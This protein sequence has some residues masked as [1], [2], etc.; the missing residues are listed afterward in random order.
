M[1]LCRLAAQAGSGRIYD[2]FCGIGNVL[3]ATVRWIDQ[4]GQALSDFAYTGREHES[5][6]ACIA[7][8]NILAHRGDPHIYFPI[9]DRE[10][11][12]SKRSPKSLNSA[13]DTGPYHVIL[14]DLPFATEINHSS[15]YRSAPDPAFTH[16]ISAVARLDSDRDAVF[17]VPHVSL[18]VTDGRSLREQL[19]ETGRIE[20][21]VGLPQS[22]Y[23]GTV[24]PKSIVVLSHEKTSSEPEPIY[25]L[26]ATSTEY[27]RSL[28]CGNVL[29]PDGISRIVD[30]VDRRDEHGGGSQL[31]SHDQIRSSG[32]NLACSDSK[33]SPAHQ[34]SGPCHSRYN[35]RLSR[36]SPAAQA[37]P[38]RHAH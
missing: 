25:F 34:H 1:P 12:T 35:P 19:L 17:A 30:A 6:L 15:A 32:Y 20:A 23:T 26:Q 38:A 33:S 7:R 14:S 9:L 2:P 13:R 4:E 5:K 29:T 22:L 16:L 27:Y 10:S 21:V 31:V 24:V 36:T 28:S 11:D 37:P 3:T 18:T 8:L